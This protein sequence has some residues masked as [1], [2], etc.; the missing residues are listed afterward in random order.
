MTVFTPATIAYAAV[1][2]SVARRSE[3]RREDPICEL[4]RTQAS[5]RRSRSVHGFAHVGRGA[6]AP[7]GRGPTPRPH[8]PRNHMCRTRRR[9][10]RPGR[11]RIQASTNNG[12]SHETW[13]NVLLGAIRCL[14]TDEKSHVL[15]L[16]PDPVR[17]GDPP[18][19]RVR[20]SVPVY[21]R[22]LHEPLSNSAGRT[23]AYGNLRSDVQ[24]IHCARATV[25][26][27]DGVKPKDSVRAAGR[28]AGVASAK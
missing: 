19:Q 5:T 27:R 22:S 14:F 24:W 17:L 6:I 26:L 15:G 1:A 7:G 13:S 4:L 23:S 3:V 8:F 2:W 16:P 18:K 11:N 28:K 9:H 10:K 21:V 20:L 12:Q 25:D